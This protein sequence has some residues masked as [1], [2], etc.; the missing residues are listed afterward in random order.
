MV[1][2]Q[3]FL[4]LRPAEEKLLGAA[5]TGEPCVC[6]A[7]RPDVPT[8]DNL[9]RADFLRFLALGGEERNA[10]HESGLRVQGAYIDGAVN[11]T[12]ATK[13]APLWKIGRAHV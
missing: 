3:D 12:G 11:L 10:V 4:P 13:L 5:L 8:E 7:A 1:S 6:V 2:M 9:V